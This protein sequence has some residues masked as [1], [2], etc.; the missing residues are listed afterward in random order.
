M[1]GEFN[2]KLPKVHETVFVAP[3]ADVIG[4]VEIG[5]QSSIWFQVVIRGDVNFIKIGKRTNIQD[6]SVLHVSRPGLL[7]DS[8]KGAP[9]ILGDDI[10]VGHQVTLHGCTLGNRILVG[11]G[12]IIM[13][14][15]IIGDDSIIAA[16]SLVTKGKEF[17]PRSLIQGS[18]AKRVREL[19]DEEVGFLKKSATNYVGD[20][21]KY[22]ETFSYVMEDCEEH[23]DCTDDTC[24]DP[25]EKE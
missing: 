10:T 16:G 23:E 4:D 17:P 14:K 2:G 11:V 21:Q 1:I 6:G 19:T 20:R 9:L 3:S 18:P 15:A 13:D 5:E 25:E 12:A 7:D 22:L 8:K 24:C